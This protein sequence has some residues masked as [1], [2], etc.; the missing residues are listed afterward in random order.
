[1]FRAARVDANQK[2]IV[3]A[4]RDNGCT[5]QHLHS[6]GKGCPDLLVGY[7]H[8]GKPYNLLMEVKDKGGKLTPEQIIWHAGWRG[9]VAV[10]TTPEEAIKAVLEY[11]K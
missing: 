6:I 1:M 10:V 11:F 2:E 4:L 5:V 3:K 8:N 9:Q 7:S